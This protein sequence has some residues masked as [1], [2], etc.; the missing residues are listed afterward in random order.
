MLVTVTLNMLYTLVVGPE[1][2]PPA[3]PAPKCPDCGGPLECL[4]FGQ[5]AMLKLMLIFEEMAL[6]DSS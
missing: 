3:K 1:S 5:S 2:C 4:G 6:I